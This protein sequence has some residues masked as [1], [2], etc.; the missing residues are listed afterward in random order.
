VLLF[1]RITPRKVRVG[2]AAEN[3]AILR[4]LVLNLLKSD[5]TKKV[6]LKASQKCAGWDHHYLLSLINIY[7]AGHHKL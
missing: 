6:G 4:H 1:C 7:T 2:H 5:T 3:F